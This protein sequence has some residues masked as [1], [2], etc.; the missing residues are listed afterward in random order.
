MSEKKIVQL[1][2]LDELFEMITLKNERDVFVLNKIYKNQ[3]KS[4]EEWI[5]LLEKS[6]SFSLN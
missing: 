5:K 4:L 3:K 1:I 2:G 6:F